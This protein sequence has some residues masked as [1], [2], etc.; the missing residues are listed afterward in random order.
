M[1]DLTSAVESC[2]LELVQRCLAEGCE[3][4]S[5]SPQRSVCP[6]TAAVQ[7]GSGTIVHALLSAGADPN[8]KQCGDWPLSV[9]VAE[10][11]EDIAQLLLEAG[12]KANLSL[13]GTTTPLMDAAAGGFTS[14][15]RL[16]LKHGADPQL[17]DDDGESAIVKAAFKGHWEIVELLT[18]HA[19][20]SDLKRVHHVRSPEEVESLSAEI[21]EFFRA[22]KFGDVTNA[23]AY[24]DA[25]GDV[26]ALDE[27][28]V[29]AIWWACMKGRKD[30]AKK[31]VD[32]GADLSVRDEDGNLLIDLVAETG[33]DE[34][35]YQYIREHTPEDLQTE[36][37]EVRK[38]L[39][40]AQQW[41]WNRPDIA[42]KFQSQNVD[43]NV[44]KTIFKCTAQSLFPGNEEAVS[45][46]LRETPGLAHAIKLDGTTLLTEAVVGS[47]LRI[48]KLLI[49]EHG[50]DPN[51]T[52]IRGRCA[53]DVA[54]AR[55]QEAGPN[56]G[57][58]RRIF[59]YL[60]EQT[61][62]ELRKRYAE[63]AEQE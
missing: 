45:E 24:L 57:T 1:K 2:D 27:N 25:G 56:P 29:S 46:L 13:E 40:A 62:P 20:E 3:P 16:L 4:N 39:I 34:N 63:I 37:A 44:L 23:S 18:P 28:G 60:Y 54:A 51:L 50:I 21:S 31:L 53:L 49:E 7:A 41:R 43:E 11:H 12:A 33:G 58:R 8:W 47:N 42:S 22:V 15:A 9:A 26:N 61:S 17:Q 48:V 5:R 38:K 19:T 32:A 30:L 14:I 52:D 10:G 55:L 59:D 35:L 36:A 6:L